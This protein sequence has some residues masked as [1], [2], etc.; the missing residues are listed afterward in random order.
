VFGYEA[1]RLT[2]DEFTQLIRQETEAWG[3]IVRAAHLRLD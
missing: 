2:P 3:E 1:P